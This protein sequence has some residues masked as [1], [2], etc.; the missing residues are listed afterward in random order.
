MSFVFKEKDSNL[1]SVVWLLLEF[2]NFDIDLIKTST[3][4]N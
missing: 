4:G 2:S 3:K 1:L